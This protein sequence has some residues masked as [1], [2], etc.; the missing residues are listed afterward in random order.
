MLGN[1]LGYGILAFMVLALIS[2]CIQIFYLKKEVSF[3]KCLIRIMQ[4]NDEN[5]GKILTILELI[6]NYRYSDKKNEFNHYK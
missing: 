5:K 2:E 3:L 1:L 6:G 4:E